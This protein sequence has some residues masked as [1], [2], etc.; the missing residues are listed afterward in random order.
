MSYTKG[1]ST[2]LKVC[3]AILFIWLFALTVSF[4]MYVSFK[5]RQID[6]FQVQIKTVK[7]QK[8][9]LQEERLYLEKQRKLFDQQNNTINS[10]RSVIEA[11]NKRIMEQESQI[12]MQKGNI[13]EQREM[14]GELIVQQQQTDSGLAN[15]R[16]GQ[17]KLNISVL[18]L[19]VRHNQHNWTLQ[20]TIKELEE[21]QHNMTVLE[22]GFENYRIE[23]QD[24][25]KQLEEELRFD[26]SDT[27][28][29]LLA[30][31]NASDTRCTARQASMK[32]RL[33]DLS[34]TV[35]DLEQ[36]IDVMNTMG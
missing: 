33:D 13:T 24:S 12:Q 8:G 16:I 2:R 1:T 9:M 15:L 17:E 10:L 30:A 20:E 18:N 27:R 11:Q 22:L 32:R 25:F 23:T 21:T 35:E 19:T 26:I 7:N 4:V 36:Q 6:D 29:S 31:L 34:S 5:E 14:L 3:G 28:V